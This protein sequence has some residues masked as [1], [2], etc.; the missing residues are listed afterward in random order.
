MR[1]AWFTPLPPQRSGIS[2]YSAELLPLLAPKHAIDVVTAPGTT[3]ERPHPLVDVVDLWEFQRRHLRHPYDGVV[4]QLGNAPCHDYMWPALVRY[5]GLVVLHDGQLHHARARALLR[6][7]R[8]DDY[9]AEFA[10]NHPEAPRDLPEFV[11][12]GLQGS[13]YFLWPM[14]RLVIEQAALVAVHSL[15]L[16]EQ[17]RAEHPDCQIRHIPMGVPST[18]STRPV[19]EEARSGQAPSTRPP[20]QPR[21]HVCPGEAR[22]E[23]IPMAPGDADRAGAGM[24]ALPADALVFGTFGLVTPEK[25]IPQIL[26]TFAAVRPSMRPSRLVLVGEVAA[27]YDVAAEIAALGLTDHVTITGYV[28][29]AEVAAWLS[30][31]DVALCLRWPSS[32]ESSASWLRCLAAGLATVTTDLV[33]TSDVPSLDPRTWLPQHTRR[34]AG[35]V[36]SPPTWRDAV[37][38][39]IDVL[40]EEH[41]LGL[42]M[43]R[44]ARDTELRHAVGANAHAHWQRHHTLDVMR[45]GYEAAL[46]AIGATSR[47]SRPRPVHLDRDGTDVVARISALVGVSLPF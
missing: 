22:A 31:L 41:S 16:A 4:Y 42:A 21:G 40:D 25:R 18:P 11:V 20:A 29:D 36:S 10:A 5:P 8:R 23:D 34:D 45:D 14:R 44:L 24:M 35:A 43:V 32:G 2:A 3:A 26:R 7:G 30:R 6:H 13:P 28:D 17:L 1:L 38:V 9:R 37:T 27:H 33:H 12:N 19:M 46:A 39:A 15:P 47:V